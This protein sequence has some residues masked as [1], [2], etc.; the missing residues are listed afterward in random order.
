MYIQQYQLFANPHLVGLISYAD[1]QFTVK[2]AETWQAQRPEIYG[3][4]S[5]AWKI[6]AFA[7]F[8]KS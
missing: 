4:M 2:S 6:K 3:Y 5:Y 8:E 7:D 1:I